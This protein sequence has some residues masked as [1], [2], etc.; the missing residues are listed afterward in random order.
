MESGQAGKAIATRDRGAT[1]RSQNQLA[2]QDCKKLLNSGEIGL[3]LYRSAKQTWCRWSI[4]WPRA[5]ERLWTHR[6]EPGKQGP[7]PSGAA[8]FFALAANGI[9]PPGKASTV[10]RSRPESGQRPGCAGFCT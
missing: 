10:G 2:G 4:R 3:I 8:D 9:S 7:F 5:W 6:A 1:R